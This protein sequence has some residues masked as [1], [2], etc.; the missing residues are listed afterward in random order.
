MRWLS[1]M[2]G[3]FSTSLCPADQRVGCALN[4]L[5]LG[6]KDWWRLTTRSFSDAQR[7]AVSW[8]QFRGMFS[9]RYV[10]RDEKEKLARKFLELNQDLESVTESTGMFIERAM[11]CPEF[12]S[13]QAQMP[14]YPSM[15]KGVSDSS[16]LR[17]GV[18]PCWSCRRPPCG[19]S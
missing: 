13:E 14:R 18:R 3:C 11:F 1:D 8:D 2:E 9:T 6:A 17:G 12:A 7:V 4:L 19:V 10:P 5:R 16:C 15:L